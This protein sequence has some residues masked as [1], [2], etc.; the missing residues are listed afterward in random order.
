MI[1]RCHFNVVMSGFLVLRTASGILPAVHTLVTVVCFSSSGRRLEFSLL[2]SHLVDSWFS[3]PQDGSM[4][5]RCH[6]NV[7]MSGFLVLRTASGILPAVSTH[8]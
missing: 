5:S 1:S 6:F 3:R 7:V 2:C 4:I 8:W